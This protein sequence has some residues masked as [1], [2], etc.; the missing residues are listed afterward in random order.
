MLCVWEMGSLY[1]R[2]QMLTVICTVII[3]YDLRSW[4]IFLRCSSNTHCYFDK[5][6]DPWNVCTYYMYVCTRMYV[7]M[8]LR[9]HFCMYYTCAYV[10]MYLFMY[11][12]FVQSMLALGHSPGQAEVNNNIQSKHLASCHDFNQSRPG[13]H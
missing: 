6:M 8:Y 4:Y 10:C 1:K 11:V 12:L 9:M 5:L 3:V 13:I 2:D 7:C